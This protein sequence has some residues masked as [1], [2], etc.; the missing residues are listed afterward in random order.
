MNVSSVSGMSQQ[1]K[2][3]AMEAL[4]DS[5][6]REAGELTSPAWHGEVLVARRAKVESGSAQ[7]VSLDDLKSERGG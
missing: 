1:E 7:Y 3:Q 4:W 6:T 5:L 2:L